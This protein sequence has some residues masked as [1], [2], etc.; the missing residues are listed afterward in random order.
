MLKS[1]HADFS[2]LTACYCSL[3]QPTTDWQI[4]LNSLLPY[5]LGTPCHHYLGSPLAR[6]LLP[7]NETQTLIAQLLMR[8]TRRPLSH[9]HG[10][11][12]SLLAWLEGVYHSVAE[13]C[14]DQICYNTLCLSYSQLSNQNTCLC[15]IIE[16]IAAGSTG[17]IAP[18]KWFTHSGWWCSIQ[19]TRAM[20]ICW[21]SEAEHFVW[22]TI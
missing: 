20:A 12:Y 2:A 3:L 1:S 9:W 13:L 18:V 21:N 14:V 5:K 17:R 8:I 16:F 22:T 6:R 10:N 7:S 11:D 19:L 4:T 15:C